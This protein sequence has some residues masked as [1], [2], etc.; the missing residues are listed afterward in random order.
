MS[1]EQ[2]RDV[3]GYE[4]YYEV[5]DLGR[6]RRVRGGR[7]ATAGRILRAKEPNR[8]SDYRR[9]Q[10]CRNDI[11][12]TVTVHFLVC[13]AF[14]G[15]RPRKKVPNHINMDKLDNRACN[16]EWCTLKQNA[17]HALKNGRQ[18]GKSRP[19][20]MNPRAKLSESQVREVRRLKG[21]IGQRTL[22]ALCGVS[23][24]AIQLIH[25]GKNWK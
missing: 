19:G 9:I 17:Q 6:V 13:E 18:G 15:K 14:H 21:V 7:G 23:K 3:R 2:W 12:R 22:A 24:T 10:L 16:L 5:S 20:E 1:S 25:Q 8:T 4:G 11:K